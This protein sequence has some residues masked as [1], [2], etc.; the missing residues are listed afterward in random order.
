MSHNRPTRALRSFHFLAIS[1]LL[2]VLACRLP[3]TPTP[4]PSP[5]LPIT[6]TQPPGLS[7]TTSTQVSATQASATVT[8]V[9]SPTPRAVPHR[10]GIRR[11]Y[12]IATFYEQESGANFV[13][14][15]VNYLDLTLRQGIYE[16]RAFA[17]SEF[18]AARLGTA[19]ETLHQAGYNTVRLFLDLCNPGPQCIVLPDGEGL[20]PIYL[21]SIV[22]TMQLARENGLVLILASNDLPQGGGYEALAKQGASE[23][24]AAGRNALFLT[25]QGIQAASQYWSDLLRGLTARQ[26]PFEV[27]LGWELLAEQWFDAS[28]PPFSLQEGK[29]STANG[30]TYDLTNTSA[31]RQMAVEGLEYYIQQVRQA[32]HQ[33][34]PAGMVT[35]GFFTPTYPHP[36]REGDTRYVETAQL[37]S[38]AELDFYDFHIYPSN[39]LSMTG[40]IENLGVTKFYEKPILMGE[41]GAY[42]SEFDSVE[43]AARA[44][45]DWIA[46]SCPFGFE[47]WLVWSYYPTPPELPDAT[48][49]FTDGGSLL[50]QAVSPAFQPDPCKTTVLRGD[51]LSQGKAVSASSS[52]P[53]SPPQAAVDGQLSSGWNPN[54]EPPKWIEIDLGA[55]YDIGKIVLTIEQW[56]DGDTVHEIWAAGENQPL[57]KVGEVI[58]WTSNQQVLEWIPAQPLNAVRTVRIVTIQ[59]PPWMGWLEIEIL[60]K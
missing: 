34:D 25:S 5:T 30:K 57:T 13:A 43:A 27:V 37:L 39:T 33:S 38:A 7:Q 47:G 35:M 51:N 6:P 55:A 54:M 40:M 1:L 31:R 2:L 46:A 15:G 28:Q 17:A 10:I 20:N 50:M 53:D 26:A 8:Q 49:G 44:V 12:G 29:V 42:L 11:T 14:R 24:I 22:Q 59:G 45:Q 36:W 19:F 9:P 3:E 60:A 32:I 48:W 16:N 52:L 21:D 23:K 41:T 56:P 4:V 58:G 18:D